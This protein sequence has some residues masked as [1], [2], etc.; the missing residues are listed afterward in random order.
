MVTVHFS[1]HLNRIVTFD[2]VVLEVFHEDD[3]NK[4]THIHHIKDIQVTTDNK[5]KRALH[6]WNL[7]G[8]EIVYLTFEEHLDMQVNELVN[9]IRQAK[10]A[11]RGE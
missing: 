1:S 2:G 6:V 7:R 3:R 9:Q 8:T 10:A 4:R 11:F 5:G